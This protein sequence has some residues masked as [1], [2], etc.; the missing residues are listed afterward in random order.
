MHAL[1]NFLRQ[2]LIVSVAV[3]EPEVSSFAVAV[4]V[5]VVEPG[6]SSVDDIAEP[7]ASVDTAFAFEV[8][9]P[10]SVA[11]VEVDSCGRPRDLAFPIVDLFANSSSSV[12]V[13]GWES[14][15]NSIGVRSN[16]GLCSIFSNP[17]PHHNKNL[18]HRYN[19]PNPG[20]NNVNDTSD[21]PMDATT[22]HSR[23]KA[24]RIYQ[25]QRTRRSYQVSLSHPE[26]PQTPRVA[27]K[28]RYLYL[29]LPEQEQERQSPMPI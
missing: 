9:V 5:A 12:A 8:L 23:N 25:E 26:V 2:I 29:S 7:Q 20:H 17:G 14:V 3:V 22:N 24:L 1:L 18:E 16:Y 10:A 11:A 19:M 13:V 4:V 15:H 21:L 6:A 27:M 28:S